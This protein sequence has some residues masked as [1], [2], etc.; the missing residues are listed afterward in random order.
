MNANQGA[1]PHMRFFLIFWCLTL[2]LQNCGQDKDLKHQTVLHPYAANEEVARYMENFEGRGDLTDPTSK[3]TSPDM[4]VQQFK[5]AGDLQLEL[6]LSEPDIVQPLHISFDHRGRMWVVQYRQYPYPKGLKIT[7]IDNHTRVKFDKIPDAPPLGDKGA[8]RITVFED[9]DGDGKYD[10]SFDAIEGLNIA[11]SVAL[12]RGKIWVL[13]PPYLLAYK[14]ADGDGI[15]EDNPEVHLKGFGLE[16]THSVANSLTWGPDGWLYGVQ[17]STTTAKIEV[18]GSSHVTSFSGQ[19][20]WRYHPEN[21]TFEIFAEGGGNNPFNLEFDRKGRIYSG[22]NGYGRGPYYKQGAYY[23]KSWGKHGPLTNPYAFG[24]LPN[25]P[26]EGEKKRFTHSMI[27]YEGNGFP[28][29]YQGKMLAANPLHN[30]LQLTRMEKLGSSFQNIDESIILATEDKWFRPVDMKLGPDGGI[31]LADWYDSRLSHVDPRDTWHKS[32]GRIYKLT[33][34]GLN[35]NPGPFDLSQND[36]KS[37]IDYLSHPNKW[38]RQQALKQLGDRGDKQALP[39]LFKLFE[40][41]NDQ[42]ALEALWGVHLSGGFTDDF[43]VKALAH[44]D[45]H[46]RMWALRL[47]GDYQKVSADLSMTLKSLA[48]KEKSA[49]VR[50]QL[51]ATAKRLPS[52][53]ALPIISNLAQYHDDAE[54]PDIPMQLWWALE[55]KIHEN[56]ESALGFFKNEKHWH[57]PVAEKFLLNRAMQR[58]AMEGGQENLRFCQKLLDLA[59]GKKQ[60]EI[61]VAGLYQGLG[62]QDLVS[63]PETLLKAIQPYTDDY[64]SL[65]L[66]LR[67]GERKDVKKAFS[68]IQDEKEPIGRRLSLIH[69]F[70]EIHEPEAVDVLLGLITASG[71]SPAIQQAALHALTNY[72]DPQIGRNLAKTYPSIRAD[73]YVR[74]AAI[75]LFASRKSWALS[76]LEEIDRHKIIHKEDVPY[77]LARNFYLLGDS[78]IDRLTGKLWPQTLPLDAASIST[79]MRRVKNIV[80]SGLG[81]VFNGKS[82]FFSNCGQCHQMHG[83]GGLSGPDLSGYDRSQLDYWLLH[84]IDPNADI[85]EGF[86]LVNALTD[87]GRIITGKLTETEG[88]TMRVVPPSG[89]KPTTLTKEKLNKM[90]VSDISFM[91]ERLLEGLSDQEIRDLFSFLM[92]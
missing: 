72:P 58:F 91:P 35:N 36:T 52:E 81:D 78:E 10:R 66:S 23:I 87:D 88:Q 33:G 19:A 62:G 34:N 4:A 37:L 32:S 53:A 86:E 65:A 79:E 11:T 69:I 39:L 18:T 3:P 71:G 83:E 44:R 28:E 47:I 38:F 15:P 92:N 73:E 51:A 84:I 14:D 13:N 7:D 85:R 12:G 24:Y 64:N 41:G 82:V 75:R 56:P 59:P 29:A 20:I 55:A 49:E 80:Q 31:Y 89:G 90:D 67:S 70:G 46:V 8:D 17:G 25:M 74:E 61:L 5:V 6:V 68:I 63:L 2:L 22:S 77:A 30:Y 9:T 27:I 50:S 43:A 57:T 40:K 60:A 1:D 21:K 76:F 26:L 48:T 42:E 45:P 16:D 54:D